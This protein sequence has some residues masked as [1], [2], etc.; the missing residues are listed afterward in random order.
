MD[1]VKTITERFE[2]GDRFMKRLKELHI[3]EIVAV[4]EKI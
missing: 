1:T 2:Y 3:K 4:I